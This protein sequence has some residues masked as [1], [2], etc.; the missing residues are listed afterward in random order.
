LASRRAFRS[1]SGRSAKERFDRNCIIKRMNGHVEENTIV[2]RTRHRGLRARSGVAIGFGG[3]VH[4]R[5]FTGGPQTE[6]KN[7]E[8]QNRAVHTNTE[9]TRITGITGITS[10]Y[11]KIQYTT[12]AKHRNHM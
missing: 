1:P 3:L 10:E 8:T 5:T 9:I 11:R 2:T 6:T 7:S 12:Y 4:R